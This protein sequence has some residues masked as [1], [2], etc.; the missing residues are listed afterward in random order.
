[1]MTKT[2]IEGL[3][4]YFLFAWVNQIKQMITKFNF[5]W[6]QEE[7]LGLFVLSVYLFETYIRKTFPASLMRSSSSLI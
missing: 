4:L 5:P 6:Y 1:M 7:H 2:M 3:I